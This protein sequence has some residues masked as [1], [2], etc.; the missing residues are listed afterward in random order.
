M[1]V[2]EADSLYFGT[3]KP[4]GVVSD[5]EWREFVEQ[6]ITPVFPGFTEFEATGHWR[7]AAE[8]THVIVIVHPNNAADNG[9]IRHII[10]EYKRRFTQDAVFWTRGEAQVPVN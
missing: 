9:N 2:Q 5:A 1:E 4:G 8:R 3:N 7:G 6:T 10:E